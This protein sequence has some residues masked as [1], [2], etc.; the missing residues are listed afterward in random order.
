[1]LHALQGVMPPALQ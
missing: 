1:M